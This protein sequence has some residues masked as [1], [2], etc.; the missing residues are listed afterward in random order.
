MMTQAAKTGRQKSFHQALVDQ[1]LH[2]KKYKREPLACFASF[3]RRHARIKIRAPRGYFRI[4]RNW[5]IFQP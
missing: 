5:A 4:I 2:F 3:H 1:K